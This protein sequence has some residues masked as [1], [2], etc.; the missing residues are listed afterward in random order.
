MSIRFTA[1]Y[2]RVSTP[3]QKFDAQRG[4]LL[5]VAARKGWRNVREY[6][7]VASGFDLEREGLHCLIRD[8]NA[9]LLARV[10]VQRVDRLGR[11]LMHLLSLEV[12]FDEKRVPLIAA[13][14]GVDTSLPFPTMRLHL[15]NLMVQAEYEGGNF[16]ERTKP[17]LSAARKR[18]ATLGRPPRV[19]TDEMRDSVRRWM[20]APTTIRDLALVLGVAVGTAQ[21]FARIVRAGGVL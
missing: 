1:L 11:D 6:N 7:D 3:H 18:G 16:G 13:S 9:G 8:L 14:E 17:G 15:H 10:L 2:L 4:E 19:L 20:E 12:G 21:K 5:D